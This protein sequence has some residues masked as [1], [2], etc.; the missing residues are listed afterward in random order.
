[1]D[2]QLLFRKR[3]PLTE[4]H[5]PWL[6]GS[7]EHPYVARRNASGKGIVSAILVRALISTLEGNVLEA[8]CSTS[9]DLVRLEVRSLSR[10][11][12]VS[13]CWLD[14]LNSH[15]GI[16]HGETTR[17]TYHLGVLVIVQALADPVAAA[18]FWNAYLLLLEVFCKYGRS[19]EIKPALCHAADELYYL[20]RYGTADPEPSHSRLEALQVGPPQPFME[21]PGLHALDLGPLTDLEALARLLG[22]GAV[23]CSLV[24]GTLDLP[25]HAHGFVGWQAEALEQALVA[26]D[27]ILLTGPTGT[28]KTFALHQVTM[29]LDSFLVTIEGKEGLTDL[30]FLGAI[31][32]QEDGTRRWVDGPLLRAMRQ[33]RLEPVL[34]FLDEVNRIPRVHLNILLGLMNPKSKQACQQMG[35]Q[36]HGDGPFY[37]VET[38]MTSEIVSC[39]AAHLRIVA[40]GNFGRLYHV[41]D[42]D[43]A[44]RRRFDTLIE[45]D[46]LEYQDEFDL[47]RREV[48][49]VDDRT[50]EALIKLAQETRRLMSNGELPGCIDTASLL[51]WARKCAASRAYLLDEIMQAA[52]LTWADMVCGRDHTGR[53]NQGSFKALADYLS[54]LAILKEA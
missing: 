44:V 10:P 3:T 5:L 42:L 39:P 17:I 4:D 6:C 12:T 29:R 46:Y 7:E 11:R 51:N 43:P 41:Y 22:K 16:P 2:N 36:L 50:T 28:G 21:R 49:K 34:L 54:S 14:W 30:D 18:D 48:L 24:Q 40:A 37:L 9:A 1:M 32:P 53:I 33:A 20:L 45:F 26:G 38:P 31:L 15:C 23:E 25:A 52:Q 47:L 35:I 27:N 19:G 13:R 8:E